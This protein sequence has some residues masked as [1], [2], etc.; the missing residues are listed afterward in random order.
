[1][2]TSNTQRVLLALV[3]A[4]VPC[5][6]PAALAGTTFTWTGE[7]PEDGGSD[8]WTEVLNWSPSTSYPGEN[9]ND[10]IA[11]VNDPSPRPKVDQNAG[12]ITIARL[13]VG[14]L[15]RIV[16]ANRIAVTTGTSD[17]GEARFEGTVSLEGSSKIQAQ[18]IW[19][20]SKTENTVISTADATGQVTLETTGG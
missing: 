20:N 17:A 7:S 4:L 10:D 8:N 1:M 2:N 6:G 12:D 18:W 19:V 13:F 9:A 11:I 5:Y 16:L 3:L 15:H 14:H